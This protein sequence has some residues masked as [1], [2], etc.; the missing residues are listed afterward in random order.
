MKIKIVDAPDTPLYLMA[1]AEQ[2]TLFECI[3]ESDERALLLDGV[4]ISILRWGEGKYRLVGEVRRF[5]SAGVETCGIDNFYPSYFVAR[6]AA[7]WWYC[8]YVRGGKVW[9]SFFTC[10]LRRIRRGIG[11][12]AMP[13]RLAEI[14]AL[15]A[16]RYEFDESVG[17]W[18]VRDKGLSAD[19][20]AYLLAEVRRLRAETSAR[21]WR[22]EDAPAYGP[23][24]EMPTRSECDTITVEMLD[25]LRESLRGAY[26]REVMRCWR[27]WRGESGL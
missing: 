19:D 15:F 6:A 5:A 2:G 1:Y 14:E 8:F 18:L 3:D 20:V 10:G 21:A 9:D 25:K 12:T 23:D 7:I 17:V 22:S 26:D 24:V 11:R 4:F 16:E 13:D 27:A